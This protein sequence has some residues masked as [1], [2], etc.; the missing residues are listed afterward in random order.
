MA[1]PTTSDF[2]VVPIN[3]TDLI[4]FFRGS[5]ISRPLYLRYSTFLDILSQSIGG[6]TPLLL[7]TNSVDNPSQAL[8][9]LIQGSGITITDNGS[10]GVTIATT[11]G[12]SFITS[13]SDTADID[14][15]VALSDLTATL[16]TTGVTPNT[17]GSATQVPQI[18]VDSKGRITG[19]TL[20]TITAGTG[21]VVS[22]GTAGLISGGPITVSG[23]ITT[24]MAS[25]KLVGRYTAGP[26]I[27]EEITI[28]TGINLS[29]SGVLTASGTSGVSSVNLLTGVV[30]LT[31]TASRLSISAANVFDIDANYAGQSTITTLGTIGT[32]TWNG[33]TITTGYGGT[34]LNAIGTTLQLLRVNAGATALEY[35][36]PTY[37][38]SAITSLNGLTATTQTFAIPGTTGTA[39]NWNSV[40]PNHTLNI[41]L[42][43]TA[44][45]TAGL[46]SKTDYDNF[47]GKLSTT[48]NNTNIFV[49]NISNVATGVVMSG[50]TT[51]TNAGA[52]TIANN[53]VTYAKMQA[54]SA[55]SK[56]LGSSSTTTPIQEIT[57]GTNLSMSGTTLNAT[58]SS[59]VDDILGDASDGSAT[60]NGS[61]TYNTFSTLAGSTYTL[62]RDI[63]LQDLTLNS[64][65]T[66]TTAGFHIY[67][68]GTITV[69]GTMGS[70]GNSGANGGS[71]T[72]GTAAGGIGLF[73][74]T[75]Y[76]TTLN[77]LTL[78][79]TAVQ[80][81]GGTGANTSLAAV[82]KTVNTRYFGGI[83]GSGGNGNTATSGVPTGLMLGGTVTV[84]SGGQFN[85][86]GSIFTLPQNI[87]SGNN[88][89]YSSWPGGGGG[90]GLNSGGAVQG[91]GGGGGSCAFGLVLFCK[92][93][94]IGATGLIRSNGG[95]G[96]TGGNATGA[97]GTGGGGGGGGGGGRVWI[98]IQT[99]L[100]YTLTSNQIQAKGGTGGTGGSGVGTQL[101]L[102]SQSG[103]NGGDGYVTLRIL[104]AG[105][106]TTYTGQI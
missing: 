76:F 72:G 52:V 42:A 14:L 27:M 66:L 89:W 94:T 75:S 8:L 28:G 7:Q 73:N 87:A 10:G 67:A 81:N 46:I 78:G 61:T 18:T 88:V 12:A 95:A 65:V 24:S 57:L 45:V 84:I 77:P 1:T 39:P 106:T 60:L 49:G 15:N 58:S 38:T 68:R 91:G 98:T 100:T 90:V 64:G 37:L 80:G 13:I 93:L 6:G 43:S 105:T 4:A 48:L 11:G 51:I 86:L 56:L 92:N 101:G 71:G 20:V 70:I 83:G 82:G 74:V 9:N 3:G 54:V 33:T 2:L 29:V 79:T 96:G 21:S 59:A 25:G 44:S 97:N 19:V 35:F 63:Y 26:G 50:D 55:T 69:N 99:T 16:T 47:A 34:G 41:P 40:S 53:A 85:P 36:T 5:N 103:S 30:P 32:G 62:I 17:Y 104:S 102:L 31:G 22:V 23:T